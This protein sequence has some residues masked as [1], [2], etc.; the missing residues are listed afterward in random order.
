MIAYLEGKLV[1]KNPTQLILDVQG[2]GYCVNIPISTFER[3][4]EIGSK[5]KILTYY[6]VREDCLQLYGFFTPEE[7]WLFETL[8]SVNGIGPKTG[9]GILSFISVEDFHQAIMDEQI[10]F[11]TN[12]PGIGR[13]TAQ[14]LIV[15]LK[16]KLEKLDLKKGL[17]IKIKDREGSQIEQEAIL[18]LFSL[19]Y[20]RYEAKKAIEKGKEGAK[21][22]L[23]VEELIKR[24]LRKVDRK[25]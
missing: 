14:R 7:K 19:G 21:E 23:S 9:L 8:L 15:E 13:K 16:E 6:Y 2:V 12:I 4:G 11:L 17:K 10:D 18:A 20:N 3:I 25:Q 22:K 5:V 1:E 24:A